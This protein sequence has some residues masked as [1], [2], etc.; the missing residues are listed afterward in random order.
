MVTQT[1]K[2]GMAPLLLRQIDELLQRPC[3][4]KVYRPGYHKKKT[5]TGVRLE[6]RD[7]QG[8]RPSV[9][10]PGPDSKR[11]PCIAMTG[12]PPGTLCNGERRPA[13]VAIASGTF[14]CVAI[15]C[16]VAQMRHA[17]GS[18]E[19]RRTKAAPMR[20]CGNRWWIC[21]LTEAQ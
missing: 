19:K 7:H 3:N 9:N 15:S 2:S 11:P 17:S 13:S 6:K 21:A 12:R 10:D 8:T 1:P 5:G 18:R 16:E 14:V 4:H 20:E